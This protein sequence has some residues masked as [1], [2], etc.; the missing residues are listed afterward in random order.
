MGMVMKELRIRL[1]NS[2][3]VSWLLVL[4]TIFSWFIFPVMLKPLNISIFSIG[5]TVSLLFIFSIVIFTS[6][7]NKIEFSLWHKTMLGC[8]GGYLCALL[9]STLE[10]G[11]A[12]SLIQWITLAEKF[13]FFI[14]ILLYIQTKYIVAT[15]RIYANVMVL[16]VIFSIIAVF[17]FRAGVLPLSEIDLGGKSVAVYFGSYYVPNTPIC[18]PEP[19]YRIQGLSEEPGTYAFVLLPAFFGYL[20]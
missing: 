20:S 7:I 3:Y 6:K 19:I 13:L 12:Y 16:T 8:W 14:F 4:I 5:F 18:I 15:L 10:S 2:K 17:S 9:V 1:T 11:S